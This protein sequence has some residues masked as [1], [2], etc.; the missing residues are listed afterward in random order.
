M[1]IKNILAVYAKPLNREQKSAFNL[2][3]RVLN[4]A[5]VRYTL[6]ERP[7][8]NPN[9]FKGKNLI[10]AIGGDGTFL[11]ASHFIKDNTP[12]LGVNSDTKSKEGFYMACNRFDFEKKFNEIRKGKFKIRKL[13]QN[14]QNAFN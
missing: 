11:R 10:I 5:S 14:R 4:K 6:L 13:S 12:L 3:K 1:E 8:L 2:V 7:L 9:A